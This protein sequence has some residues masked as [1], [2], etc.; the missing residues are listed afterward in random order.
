MTPREKELT[1][2]LEQCLQA[3]KVSRS[4][5]ALLSLKIDLLV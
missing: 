4:E 5:N 2:H 3:L 1:R